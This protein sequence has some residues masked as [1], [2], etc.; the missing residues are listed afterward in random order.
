LTIVAYK[1]G[2][3]ASDGRISA[4]Q[5]IESDTARKVHKLA[6][7]SLFGSAGNWASCV[8][9]LKLLKKSLKDKKE[10]PAVVMRKLD[11]LFVT[12]EKV[13]WYYD[14]GTWVKWDV[15][16][17][18]A[19]GSG[20]DTANGAMDA[21]ASAREAVAITCKRNVFCGGTIRTVELEK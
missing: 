18:A 2:V 15:V 9:M 16:P 20:A 1:D 12:P 6:D 8:S 4:G 14:R 7:G 13:L 17:Y 11:A 19:I 3:M 10:L 21:G 5:S